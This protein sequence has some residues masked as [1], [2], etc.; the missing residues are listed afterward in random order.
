MPKKKARKVNPKTGKHPG[1]RPSVVTP[2]VVAKLESAFAIGCSKVEAC[3]F[4]GIGR[5]AFYNYLA[6]NPQF[7]DRILELQNRPILK[8]RNTIVDSLSDP[9]NAQW[10]LERKRKKEFS[11][12]SELTGA[13]GGPLIVVS[14]DT[15]KILNEWDEGDPEADD[16]QTD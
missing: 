7:A 14:S 6:K 9:K 11:T 13:E 10:F 2:D 1:G 5:D 4:A 12:R 8:A 16:I 3:L 15:E